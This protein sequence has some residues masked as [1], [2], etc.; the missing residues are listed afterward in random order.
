M[1]KQYLSIAAHALLISLALV[2]LS[3]ATAATYTIS[4]VPQFPP[5]EIHRRWTPLLERLEKMTGQQ[6]KLEQYSTIP[7]FE[8]AFLRG[9]P[10]LV[11]LNPYHMV[12]ASES[13]GYA[14]LVFD[15]NKKLVGILVVREDSSIT[16]VNELDGKIVAFPA[17][18]AFG[19]SL[20]PRALLSQQGINIRARYVKTHSNSYRHVITGLSEAAGGIQKTLNREPDEIRKQLRVLYRTPAVRPHPLAAHPRVP[21]AIQHSVRDAMLELAADDSGRTLLADILMPA[22]V[23]ADYATD[24]AGLKKLQLDNFVVRSQ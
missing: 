22:P 24:Y 5:I 8:A 10:D 16:S 20:Y 21:Q 7:K 15:G 2:F 1:I 9:A 18:N 6:F 14:P 13:H 23:A 17:P 4:V 12:M 11:Y 19:A 3:P